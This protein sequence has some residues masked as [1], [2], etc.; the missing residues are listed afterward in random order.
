MSFH[1]LFAI[2]YRQGYFMKLVR[3]A[4]DGRVQYGRYES[5]RVV[6]EN[7]L[8]YSPDEIVWLPPVE[9]HT[10]A[11]GLALNYSDRAVEFDLEKPKNPVLFNKNPTTFIGHKGRVIYPAGVEYLHYENELVVVLNQRCRNVK[12]DQADSVI[13]GYTIG[14]D[15]T[16]RDFVENYYRPP[17]K[18][19]GFDT[20]GPIGPW[21]VTADE[22][23]DPANLTL[24]TFVNGD[25]RQ[26]GNTRDLTYGVHDL[27]AFITGFMT[28]EAG[29]MI[30]TGSP[31]G[32]S[33]VHPG[34]TMRCEIDNI[35]VLE[36][37]V[38]SESTNA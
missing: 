15:V 24:R 9:A 20:F 14:N 21:V 13:L 5:D 19:K 32:I 1:Q 23:R 6:A 36:N 3:F 35:G 34:D 8:T 4:A 33:H 2:C 38:I 31:Q 10:K 25:L 11:I 37:S 12:A 18:A 16:V 29:D 17:V 28:L 27:I 26:E 22:I 7:G 30:W